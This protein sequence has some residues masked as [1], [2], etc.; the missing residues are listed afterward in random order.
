MK[1]R[2]EVKVGILVLVSIFLLIWGFF[3]LKGRNI[4]SK[5]M[6]IKAR[7][8]N[9]S[10]L[11][12]AAPVTIQGYIVGAVSGLYLEPQTIKQPGG[13]DT[14]ITYAIA[15]LRIKGG[16]KIPPGAVAELVAPSLLSAKEVSIKYGGTCDGDGCLQN[17][18]VI[19]G[20]IPG[21]LDG[22]MTSAKPL[23]DT[24]GGKLMPVLDGVGQLGAKDGAL[25]DVG[26]IVDNV[27]L[28]TDQVNNLLLSVSVNLSVTMSNLKSI[29]DNIKSSNGEITALLANINTITE[30]LKG[31][32]IGE[33]LKDVKGVVGNLNKVISGLQ[34]TLNNVNGAVSNITDI[35]NF[36]E[37]D[38]LLPALISDASFKKDVEKAIKDLQLLMQDLRLH[39]ER[40]RTVLSNKQKKYEP[41]PDSADPGHKGGM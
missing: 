27:K 23:L 11:N 30:Q 36:K 28:I 19:D 3:F 26:V 20:S 17:N 38:G 9:V 41:T 16:T 7:F 33:T 29:T 18:A 31:A 8:N 2:N 14:I 13:R 35:T 5:D 22:I 10:G 24:L 4:L 12:I 34:G 1:I 6:V 32:E 21:M 40:Y 15:E 37:K 25:Q 39:P